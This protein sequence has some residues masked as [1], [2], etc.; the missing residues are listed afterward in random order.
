M[1]GQQPDE[2]N[3]YFVRIEVIP[4]RTRILRGVKVEDKDEPMFGGCV[5]WAANEEEAVEKST[6]I[7][8][9]VFETDVLPVGTAARIG[10]NYT[11]DRYDGPLPPPHILDL[12]K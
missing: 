7:T 4:V 12:L 9:V 10:T 1:T 3:L 6:A 2:G 8:K 5:L 11:I